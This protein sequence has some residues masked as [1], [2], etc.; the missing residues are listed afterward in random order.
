MYDWT[1]SDVWHA[2]AVFHYDYNRLYDL[3]HMAG[4]R[5]SQMR[6]ASPF[7]DYAKESLNLYR[8]IDPQIWVKLVGRVQGANF[9]AIYGKSKALGY[10]NITLPKGH[11]WESYTRFL[12]ATLPARLRI[13]YME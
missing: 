10:R 12:L 2:N 3:Y 1:T 11:T 9:A 5:P 8:V 13:S 6:V 4:L 7:N